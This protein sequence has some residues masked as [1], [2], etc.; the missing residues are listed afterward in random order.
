M[1]RRTRG[2]NIPVHKR[3]ALVAL[4]TT[5]P[6]MP[7]HEIAKRLNTTTSG[8]AKCYER[9]KKRGVDSAG[10]DKENYED[11]P[12]CGRPPKL[13]K[14][15]KDT[16][17]ELVLDTEHGLHRK[18]PHEVAKIHGF[19]VGRTTIDTFMEERGLGRYKMVHKPFLND[20]SKERR[21]ARAAD[22]KELGEKR[23]SQFLFFDETPI[24]RHDDTRYIRITAPKATAS[25]NRFK[26]INR[27]PA[28]PKE[29]T[30]MFRAAFGKGVKGPCDVWRPESVVQRK[31]TE[32]LVEE[33]NQQLKLKA[34][35]IF[36]EMKEAK[37]RGE[38]HSWSRR[39]KAWRKE[40]V[41]FRSVGGGIDWYNHR[42]V[43]LKQYLIP[44]LVK[45]N[46][47]RN[48]EDRFAY[49]EDNAP[50]HNSKFLDDF[51]D[52]AKKAFGVNIIILLEDWVEDWPA[53]S[54]DLNPI[55]HAWK[56]IRK[57][58]SERRGA[59]YPQSME[60]VAAAW[61]DEWEKLPQWQ[62]DAWVDRAYRS[63][64]DKIIENG[65]GNEYPD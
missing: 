9:L 55:E 60:E 25:R 18:P 4:K 1:L 53:N 22:F 7:F 34:E 29:E 61:K 50:A 15:D 40:D 17:Q 38:K 6:L 36:A 14:H 26:E 64:L 47:D 65:G 23:W 58:V 63:I 27:K 49:M 52:N 41:R 56:Y 28:F 44:Y 37:A 19:S 48:P 42:E 24:H 5:N 54:P 13:T 21:Y 43:W 30:W 11:A 16:L 2:E 31:R 35:A 57:R 59:D 3:V 32:E 10:L 45:L 39:R 51:W 46:K 33:E 8:T 20:A 62:I 12:L